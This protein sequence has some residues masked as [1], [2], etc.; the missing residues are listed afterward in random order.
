MKFSSLLNSLLTGLFA[1]GLALASF[2]AFPSSES[3][4]ISG[5]DPWIQLEEGSSL[6]PWGRDLVSVLDGGMVEW[7][8]ED[9][10]KRLQGELQAGGLVF[11]TLADDFK[12]EVH[13][14]FARVESQN[15]SALLRLDAEG[16]N[17]TVYALEHATLVTFVS[18]GEDLNA[19]LVPSGSFMKIPASK[20]GPSLARLRL[21]KLSKEFPVFDI[22]E[23]EL[24]EAEQAVL[25]QSGALYKASELAFTEDLQKNS[26]FGPARVGL[27]S[28]VSRTYAF[29]RA[30]LTFL[31]TAENRLEEVQ[32]E[33]SLQ[34]GLSNLLFGETAVG[35]EWLLEWHNAQPDTA[36]V[37]EVYSSLF[38]ALP[39]DPLYPAKASAGTLL[40]SQED[41][42][43]VLRRQFQEIE[44]LL[45][46][47]SLVQAQ[48]A[49][50]SYKTQFEQV[51]DGAHLDDVS[52]L[53]E[54]TR[55][56]YLLELLLRSY[57]VFYSTDSIELL[58]DLEDKILFLAGSD[59]DLDEERQAFVQSKLR[60]LAHL[61][62]FV[63]EKKVSVSD[64]V[65]L[66]NELL[67]D[68][69]ALLSSIHSDTAVRSYFAEKIEDYKLSVQFIDSPEFF[70]Y[71]DFNEGLRAFEAKAEDLEDLNAYLQSL[72]SG[73]EVPAELGLEEAIASVK[74]DL[75]EAGIQF[76]EVE[77]LGD[78][79]NRLFAVVGAHT[80][81]YAFEANYDRITEILY[82][83]VVEG[84]LRFSTGLTLE[85]ASGVIALAMKESEEVP[86]SE[87]ETQA[88][89]EESS[90]TEAVALSL[91]EK[92]FDE[93]G[94]KLG[95][96]HFE[97]LDLEDNLFL[98][99][100]VLTQESLLVS[101]NFDL[102]TGLVSEVVWDFNGSPQSFPD[103]ALGQLEAALFATFS[104]LSD[105]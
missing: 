58:S 69:E 80:A 68:A 23:E 42:L 95:A 28:F 33:E 49:Y 6:S 18:G 88:P 22:K 78:S 77:S 73:E 60:Y 35:E 93:A 5:E 57:S 50:I 104:A 61:F 66:A 31:P 62:E 36:K 1:A 29:L 64:A 85:N 65:P 47:G 12:V 96:F 102:D 32:K 105:Q 83:T 44:S 9:S 20:V 46:E 67:A 79:A 14:A 82:D 8:W 21:T 53:D 19:L 72:R 3:T 48:T 30:S 40:Y 101:G 45:Q 7:A 74:M 89:A 43:T 99:E 10:E 34:Y 91:V 39:G 71:D 92:A 54:I 16:Q 86:V 2:G 52:R 17:L 11:S 98:F 90:L 70:S 59:T 100:G 41:P 37:Q 26:H 81:G 4:V 13:T 15:S 63:V 97:V 76:K 25:A 87:E 56:Y 51:L 27:G 24:M 103:I 55:E 94:L 84:Q 75:T 38:F